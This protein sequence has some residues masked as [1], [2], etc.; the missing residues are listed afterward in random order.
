MP[1]TL[2][3]ARRFL[4]AVN[5]HRLHALYLVVL[6]LGLRR[7]EALELEWSAFDFATGTVAVTQTVK[8]IKGKGLLIE[9]IAKAPKSLRT[10]AQAASD[11]G[12]RRPQGRTALAPRC[13][14]TGATD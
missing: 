3:D 8:S 5:G 12:V 4:A 7:G 9:R 11:D 1:L 13:L 14:D 6:A 10:P 2:D